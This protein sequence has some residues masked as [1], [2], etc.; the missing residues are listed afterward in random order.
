MTTKEF[1]I[2]KNK[3]VKKV[4]GITLVPEEQIVDTPIVYL[5]NKSRSDKLDADICPYCT[6]FKN[7]IDCPMD[8]AD[9]HCG[10]PKSTWAHAN[11]LWVTTKKGNKKLRKLVNKYNKAQNI[12]DLQTLLW[13]EFILK[14]RL[15]NLSLKEIQDE[16]LKRKPELTKLYKKYDLEEKDP[17]PGKDTYGYKSLGSIKSNLEYISDRWQCQFR[18]RWLLDLIDLEM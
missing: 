13:D 17:R 10:N 16:L 9:N 7:C 15:E 18:V 3:I 1:I 2:K 14:E 6:T 8:T 12:S 5:E 11:T 4:T